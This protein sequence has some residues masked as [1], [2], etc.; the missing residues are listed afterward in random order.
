MVGRRIERET[1]TAAAEL[2]QDL[3]GVGITPVTPFSSDLT[4]VDLEGLRANLEYIL[5]RGARLLYPCGNTGEFTSLSF[6]EWTAVVEATIEVATGRAAVVP[7]IGHGYTT[8]R[9]MLRRAASLGAN[10]ALVMPPHPTYLA[11]SG[12][13]A[14]VTSLADEDA[15]PL[16]IYKRGGWPSGDGIIEL[17]N[18]VPVAGVKDGETDISAFARH[19]SA[20]PPSVVWTCGTAERFAPFFAAAGGSGF[21]SGL[22]NVAPHLSLDMQ[23][24][25]ERGDTAAALE[26]RE[27]CFDFEEIRARHGSANNVSAV[28]TALDARGLGGGRVRP[29][30]RDLD[31]ETATEVQGV[32]AAWF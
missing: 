31:E 18:H 21:T 14:F 10:G 4:R 5:D 29:P 1:L 25:L 26:I 22:G 13:I 20:S 9:E 17:V 32:V 27:R 11:D 28:K 2:R 23:R 12:L 7:G 3:H 24:A 6:E 16:V 15:L 19:I 8:A 30:M